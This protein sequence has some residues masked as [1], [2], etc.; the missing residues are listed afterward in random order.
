MT[1]GGLKPGI[2]HVYGRDNNETVWDETA[3]VSDDGRL[4]LTADADAM[5]PLEIEVACVDQNG[6]P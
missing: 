2:Y 5:N 6:Q 4:A 3:E 1:W